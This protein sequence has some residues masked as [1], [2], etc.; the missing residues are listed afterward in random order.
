MTDKE[1]EIMLRYQS[2]FE[3]WNEHPEYIDTQIANF[4]V[5]KFDISRS[6]AFRDIP[7]IEKLLGSIKKSAKD[8]TRYRV[9]QLAFSDHN[10]A[11]A[12]GQYTSAAILLDKIIKANKLDQPDSDDIDWS[13]LEQ[14]NLEPSSDIRVLDQRLYNPDIDKL[15]KQLR[16]KYK[17]E[18]IEDV[19][20]TEVEN[21]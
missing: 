17:G 18:N 7:L 16:S 12:N 2:T 6:Q 14:P 11:I 3:Y 8:W 10:L 5:D 13:E 9:T 15:R 20:F 19:P 4:M 1:Y 21:E